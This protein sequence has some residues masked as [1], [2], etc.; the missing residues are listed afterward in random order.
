M[1]KPAPASTTLDPDS[2]QSR[3]YKQLSRILEEM[4]SGSDTSLRERIEKELG[5]KRAT[6]ATLRERIESVLAEAPSITTS[7]RIRAFTAIA[8][9]LTV[10]AALR[11]ES[12]EPGERGS[13][14]RAYSEAFKRKAADATGGRKRGSRSAAI[15]AALADLDDDDEDGAA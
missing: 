9:V 6:D 5:L 12:N 8:R 1:S 4:E 3:L 10:F 15:D 11:K 7:E 14:V 13:A 2:V